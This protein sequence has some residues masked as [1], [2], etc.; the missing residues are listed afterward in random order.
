MIAAALKALAGWR[1][2]AAVAVVAGVLAGGAA[3]TVQGWRYDAKIVGMEREQARDDAQAAH[4]A[5]GQ[6]QT[7]IESLA[8]AGRRAAAVGPTLTAQINKITG[9]LGNAPPLPDGCSP[10]PVR[11]RS[12]TDSV[13]ATNR[14]AAGQQSGAAVPADP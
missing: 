5:L 6:L 9:A 8:A 13:R 1:G 3:W 12:L 7:D 2:Y 14:A 4:L 10:D 11:V